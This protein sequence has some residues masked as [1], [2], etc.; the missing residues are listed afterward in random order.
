MT[1]TRFDLYQVVTDR[2]IELLEAGAVPWNQ[3]WSGGATR[4]PRNMKTGKH[5]RGVNVFLLAVTGWQKGYES[6]YWLTYKQARERGGSV[7]KGE[8]STLVVFWKQVQVEDKHTRDKV[9]VPVLRYYRVFNVEQC[10]DIEIPDRHDLP[11]SEF[12]PIHEAE[13]VVAEYPNPPEINYGGSTAYYRPSTDRVVMPKAE[14]FDSP[15]EYYATLFHELVHSTGSMARLQ[16]FTR[17][18]K[19]FGSVDYSKEEL[20]AEMGAAFLC[21]HA[22]IETATIENSAAYIQGWIE[23]LRGD[24]RLVVAAGSAA[25]KAADLILGFDP[26]ATDDSA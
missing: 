6:A 20:V 22:G 24:H 19:S 13:R 18:P 25:Q 9:T 15:E 23:R 14:R 5:Y 17:A 10:E 16:R 3:P 26:T 1:S 2:I 12:A 21:G 11:V 7:L 8:E 4:Y